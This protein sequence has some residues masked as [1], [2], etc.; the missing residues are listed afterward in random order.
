MSRRNRR[1]LE[2]AAK[3]ADEST[4]PDY[5]HGAELVKG[6]S[7]ISTS[8]NNLRLV[9]WANRFRTHD[10]GHA[11]QHAELGCLLG[12]DK[13]VSK[14]AVVYVARIGR[15]GDFRLS[16]PCPMCMTIMKHM[17]IKKVVYTIDNEH[18]AT[19]NL[20][21]SNDDYRYKARQQTWR[22]ND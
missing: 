8:C 3:V 7:V 14:N 4:S 21:Q 15:S 12:V 6:G 19:I 2:I 9:N 10:C 18:H 16:K 13:T 5:R 20:K 11:T 17:G 22:L 1:F